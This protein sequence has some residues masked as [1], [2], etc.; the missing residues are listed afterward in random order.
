M[1]EKSHSHRLRTGR[2]SEK[3]RIYLVTSRLERHRRDFADWRLGRLL[4]HELREAQELGITKSLAWVVM[5]DH[6]HWLVELAAGSLP[7]IVRRV[8][9]RTAIAVNKT[10]ASQGRIWQ[11]GY[12]D[13]AVRHEEDMIHFFARYIVANPLRARLARRI[14]DYPL[15]DAI[16]LPGSG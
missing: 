10:I 9:S 14:G 1:P 2:F 11:P 16:W 12:H 7:D 8:K 5:P 4:V 15:W 13:I 3:G 6:F